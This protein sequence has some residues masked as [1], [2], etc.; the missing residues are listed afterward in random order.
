MVTVMLFEEKTW[1]QLC[2]LKRRH[3]YSIIGLFGINIVLLQIDFLLVGSIEISISPKIKQF[4][5]CLHFQD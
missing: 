5:A 3:G 4:L 2:Y 1:L